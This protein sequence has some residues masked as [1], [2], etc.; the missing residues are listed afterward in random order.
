MR[1]GQRVGLFEIRAEINVNKTKH[2]NI[3]YRE[4]NNNGVYKEKAKKGEAE[5]D[6]TKKVK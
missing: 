4:I 1:K 2:K 5:K 6:M 3:G